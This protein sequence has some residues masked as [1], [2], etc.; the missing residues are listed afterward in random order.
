MGSF[1]GK[2]RGGRVSGSL[3]GARGRADRRVG[4][5]RGKGRGRQG[6]G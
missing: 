3:R 4:L 2:G 6:S 1:Q 5:A